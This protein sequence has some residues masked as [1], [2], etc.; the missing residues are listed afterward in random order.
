M[1]GSLLRNRE[2][3]RLIVAAALLF[4]GAIVVSLFWMQF[5]WDGWNREQTRADLAAIGRVSSIDPKA[6]EELMSLYGKGYTD[7]DFFR[8]MEIAGALGYIDSLPMAEYR[9]ARMSP[10]RL[11][12]GVSIVFGLLF[13][14]AG[15]AA[16]LAFRRIYRTVRDV[17]AGADHLMRGDFRVRF[18]DG[19]EGD[20]SILGHQF[21]QLSN[22]LQLT[23]HQLDREKERLRQLVS[24][25]SHQVKTPLSSLL[26]FQELLS[27]AGLSAEERETLSEKSKGELFRMERLIRS[28][29]TMSRLEAG[30]IELRMEAT[31]VVDTIAPLLDTWKPQA[32]R[33]RIDL[34]LDT[35]GPPA[36]FRHDPFWLREALGNVIGNAIDFTPED[37]SI[38]VSVR[39]TEAS[40]SIAVRDSGPGIDPE[41]LPFL[42]HRFYQG[43]SAKRSGR[44]G[45]GIGLSLARLIAD[46]HGGR[47]HAESEPG[48]GAVFTMTF[49]LFGPSAE[50]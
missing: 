15:A 41:D 50:G 43:K 22:R 46:K 29:L 2:M 19:E 42:F 21:N 39:T 24:D 48:Q 13:A 6:A 10:G 28:M 31:D 1:N 18:P 5:V 16:W 40:L 38:R 30:I 20:L 27:D 33:K 35:S 14:A 37:G 4:A 32:E 12:L 8:G 44:G 26:L 7:A 9:E 23:L 11:F 3:K 34:T 17:S 45:T 36:S 49:P 47:L 25:V